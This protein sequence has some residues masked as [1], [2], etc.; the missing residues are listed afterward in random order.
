MGYT[1][2]WYRPHRIQKAAFEKIVEDCRKVLDE[3]ER[4]GLKLGDG[5]GEGRPILTPDA[6]LF[7]GAVNCGHALNQEIGLAWPAK[8]AVGGVVGPDTE[9][10][11]SGTWFAGPE[12][13]TRACNGDC[14][15]ETF[16]FGRVEEKQ[17]WQH[18]ERGY[19]FNFCKTNYRPYDIAVTAALIVIKHHCPSAYVLSDGEA[20]DWFDERDYTKRV[21]GP[22]SARL[23]PTIADRSEYAGKPLGKLLSMKR[24]EPC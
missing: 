20:K 22:M 23:L 6:V 13:S 2:Y 18:Y 21:G 15:Y 19:Q 17:A 1:H 12:L 10:P 3:A 4:R 16:G 7:N 11:I 14:S 5:G 9:N 24:G 8:D